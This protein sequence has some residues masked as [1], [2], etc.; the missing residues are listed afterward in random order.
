[1]RHQESEDKRDLLDN[2]DVAHRALD[3]NELMDT[4]EK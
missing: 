4:T 3:L 1:M 2:A